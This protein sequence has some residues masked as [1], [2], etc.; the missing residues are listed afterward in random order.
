[1]YGT[2]YASCMTMDAAIKYSDPA[3]LCRAMW[4]AQ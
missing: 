1:M 3:Y 4:P 2:D